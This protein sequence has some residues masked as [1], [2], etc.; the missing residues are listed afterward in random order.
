[1]S[2]ALVLL[3][4]NAGM[5]FAMLSLASYWAGGREKTS[6]FLFLALGVVGPVSSWALSIALP[7]A[8]LLAPL[9]LG[10]LACVLGLREGQGAR[11]EGR[12]EDAELG[13]LGRRLSHEPG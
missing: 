7:L 3:A 8:A 4:Y 6:G 5:L 9:S 12:Q 11:L 13:A 10:V 1:M 2:G